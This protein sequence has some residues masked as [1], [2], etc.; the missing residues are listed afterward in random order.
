LFYLDYGNLNLSKSCLS[1][2]KLIFKTAVTLT[3]KILCPN[4]IRITYPIISEMSDINLQVKLND[5]LKDFLSKFILDHISTSLDIPNPTTFVVNYKCYLNENSLLSIIY[6][7]YLYTKDTAHGLPLLK[8]IT[9]NTYSAKIYSLK[10][11]FK[12]DSSYKEI[13][14]DIVEKQI[15]KNNILLL[16]TFDGIKDYQEFYLTPTHLVL[17]YEVYEYT[18]YAHGPLI[19]QIPYIEIDDILNPI[20]P[21][22]IS[23]L[24]GMNPK[25]TVEKSDLDKLNIALS[26]FKSAV[27]ELGSGSPEETVKLWANGVRTRNGALQ[28]SVLSKELK[29]ELNKCLKNTT[30]L[31]GD[32]SPWVENYEIIKSKK[33]DS[34]THKAEVSFHLVGKNLDAGYV[35]AILTM[36]KKG[37]HWVIAKIK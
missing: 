29:I 17:C 28:Y 3:D 37:S 36:E 30:W 9:L 19:V 6:E 10:D 26:L 4:P 33:I 2:R 24:Y 12:Q 21:I 31:T 27:D 35:N 23:F 34:I 11:L 32:S 5:I 14:K 15:V 18:S 1:Y 8:A 7:L 13:L 20:F 25:E 16:K 22:K